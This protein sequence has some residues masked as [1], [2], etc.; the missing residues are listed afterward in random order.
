MFLEE[1]LGRVLLLRVLDLLADPDTVNLLFILLLAKDTSGSTWEKE[2]SSEEQQNVLFLKAFSSVNTHPRNSVIRSNLSTVLRDQPLLNAFHNF[3]REEQAIHILSFCLA[4]G[5]K[6]KFKNE[7]L[8]VTFLCIKED[9][10]RHILDPELSPEQMET[11]H[12]E[13]RELFHTFMSPSSSQRLEFEP[14]IVT[15]IQESESHFIYFEWI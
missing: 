13:A 5:K 11:L 8:N 7:N 1:L 9:F 6:T 12:L 3:L 14:E 15:Q 2:D 4:V 10:N